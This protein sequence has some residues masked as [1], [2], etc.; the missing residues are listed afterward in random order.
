MESPRKERSD[1][2]KK[3]VDHSGYDHIYSFKLNAMIEADNVA[4]MKDLIER[5]G[6]TKAA[7]KFLLTGETQPESV[8]TQ[9]VD[10]KLNYIMETLEALRVGTKNGKVSG[11]QKATVMD[12]VKSYC[13]SLSDFMS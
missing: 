11:K 7:I 6:S 2:G 13:D 9:S 1:K 4:R 8:D 3:R 12:A 10:A 5:F